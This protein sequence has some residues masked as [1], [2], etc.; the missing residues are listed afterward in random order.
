[1]VLKNVLRINPRAGERLD[2]FSVDDLLVIDGMYYMVTPSGKLVNAGGGTYNLTARTHALHAYVVPEA[3]WRDPTT[4]EHG[5]REAIQGLVDANE[6][7]RRAGRATLPGHAY[8][9][10]KGELMVYLGRADVVDLEDGR[11]GGVEGRHIYVHAGG[12]DVAGLLDGAAFNTEGFVER[13]RRVLG[14]YL[15]VQSPG[16]MRVT[17]GTA[18]VHTMLEWRATPRR[19]MDLG[20]LVDVAD[21]CT[22]TFVHAHTHLVSSGGRRFWG[23]WCEQPLRESTMVTTAPRS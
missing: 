7:L 6:H 20:P 13:C 21:G 18:E 8:L 1:M 22:V 9:S 17:P 16:A 10:P 15:Q 12:V 19:G 3:A 5:V 2:E 14:A 4:Y 23:T 11:F